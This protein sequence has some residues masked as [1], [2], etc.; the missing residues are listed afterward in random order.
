MPEGI[1]PALLQGLGVFATI[2]LIFV[3]LL[4]ALW[5]GQ[6]YTRPQVDEIIRMQQ[7]R[8]EE[9]IKEKDKALLLAEKWQQ[10]AQDAIAAND[11]NAEQGR[12]IVSLLQAARPYRR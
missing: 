2:F 6:L 12:L 1:S 11:A 5:K 4:V 10:A 3:S 8:V 9:A 7:G